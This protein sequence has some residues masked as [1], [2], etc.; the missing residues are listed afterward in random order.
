[1]TENKNTEQTN[2]MPNMQN[3]FCQPAEQ[4][5]DFSLQDEQPEAIGKTT[6]AD[7][8]NKEAEKEQQAEKKQANAAEFLS[9][10]QKSQIAAYGAQKNGEK[11]FQ[12]AQ[13]VLEEYFTL[14]EV[15]EN[16]SAEP[17]L[18]KQLMAVRDSINALNNSLAAEKVGVQLAEEAVR[19]ATSEYDRIQR[20]SDGAET[21]LQRLQ[22]LALQQE[23]AYNALLAKQRE[24]NARIKQE[25]EKLKVANAATMAAKSLLDDIKQKK[26][27]SAKLLKEAQDF[28]KDTRDKYRKLQLS[29]SQAREDA[30]SII[31]Q[32]RCLNKDLPFDMEEM[33]LLYEEGYD[34]ESCGKP[35]KKLFGKKK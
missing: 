21:E 9:A 12:M 32:L 2:E 28:D 35:K 1:M 16:V 25:E 18:H 29:F 6:L 33:L 3:D 34:T 23:N 10:A 27:A 31:T 24:L 8:L 20:E 22:K 26:D 30:S 13:K 11:A 4:Q 17:F 14:P 5:N 7:A 19:R 15:R